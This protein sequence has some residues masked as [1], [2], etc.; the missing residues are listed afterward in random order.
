MAEK[1]SR[2]RRAPKNP[3]RAAKK[4]RLTKL[5]LATLD[6][7]TGTLRIFTSERG[8]IRSRQAAGLTVGGR[9]GVR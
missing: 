9:G 7:E 8:K 5:G 6:Y 1:S 3:A 4:N 2:A